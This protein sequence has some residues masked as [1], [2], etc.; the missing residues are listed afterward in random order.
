MEVLENYFCLVFTSFEIRKL[1]TKLIKFVFKIPRLRPFIVVKNCIDLI[2]FN[3]RS[4]V[5]VF[6]FFLSSGTM[7]ENLTIVNEYRCT[8]FTFVS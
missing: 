2:N 6:Q 1:K 7:E 5:L 8:K 4:V 3:R